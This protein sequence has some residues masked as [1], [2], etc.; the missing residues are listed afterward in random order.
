MLGSFSIDWAVEKADICPAGG[1]TTVWDCLHLPVRP[2]T[3][4]SEAV[5]RI[6]SLNGKYKEWAIFK[7]QHCLHRNPTI[8]WFARLVLNP[9]EG[10]AMLG[11]RVTG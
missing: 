6:S 4:I 2:E 8:G 9:T 5:A 3:S 1:G 10:L 11:N 7:V